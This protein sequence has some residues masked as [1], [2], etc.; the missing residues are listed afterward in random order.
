MDFQ[1]QS[2]MHKSLIGT[3]DAR[4]KEPFREKGNISLC[5]PIHICN[6]AHACTIKATLEVDKGSARTHNSNKNI[7]PLD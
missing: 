5:T 3:T 7:T 2:F 6:D 4:K 1:A